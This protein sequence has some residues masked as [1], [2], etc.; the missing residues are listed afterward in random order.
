MLKKN[1]EYIVEIIDNGY[2]GEGIAKVEGIAV[3]VPNAIKGEKVKIHIVKVTSSYAYG[4]VIEILEPS[5]ARILEDCNTYKRCGGCDLRHIKYEDTLRIK[6]NI[7]QNLVNK[8]LEEKAVVEPTIGMENPYHY[9]NKAQYPLGFD[10]D[11]KP[12]I[13]IYANRTHEIIPMEHCFIQNE[14]SEEIAKFIYDYAVKNNISIYNE[15][16]GKGILRHIVLKVGV[17][18]NEIMC[19]LV[20]NA[21]EIEKREEIV[22]EL[23]HKFPSIKTVILNRNRKSTNVILG[24]ENMTIYGEGYIYDIL[25]G[26]KFKISPLSFYQIN[27]V[28][29]EK[30]YNLAIQKADIQKHETVFDL[31][32]GIGTIGIFLSKYVKKVYGIEMIEQAIQDAKENAKI[33]Q[34]DNMEFIAGNVEEVLGKLI[35]E[36]N[37]QPDTIF[38]DPPRKGLEYITIGNI[39]KVKPKKLIYI[40]CNPATLVRDIKK[41][42]ECYHINSITP[43]DMFPYTK[44]CE[45]ITSLALK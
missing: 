4:K 11:N 37:I 41:L 20:I 3:F 34:I 2:E 19:I 13:G 22:K 6:Q 8:E 31:Y 33:N 40:S 7:V 28:Q 12:V 15:K 32:C 36:K 16:T 43:V 10:K 21:K 18:T 29:T 38:V 44:H 17:K 39:L 45:I 9:R 26:Y 42:E 27:P 1:E 24:N 5:A 25:D 14:T 30:L 35:L 23:I